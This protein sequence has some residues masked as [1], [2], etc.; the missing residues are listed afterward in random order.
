LAVYAFN[1][2]TSVPYNAAAYADRA[3]LINA[4]GMTALGAYAGPS[5]CALKVNLFSKNAAYSLPILSLVGRA[6]LSLSLSLS[7]NSKVWVKSGSTIYYDGDNGWPAPGWR[8][9]FGRIDGKYSGPDGYDHYYLV[10]GDGSITDLRYNSASGLY[11]SRNSTWMDFNDSTGVLRTKDGTQITYSS[12]GGFVQP[13]QI[14]D[15]NGNYITINYT[16]TGQQISSIVDTVGRTVSFSYNGDGTL[17]TITKSGFNNASRTWTFGY[18]STSLSC[19]FNSLTVNA[20]SSPK[21][22]TSLTYPNGTKVT[23][24]YNSCGQMYEAVS[25]SSSD[26]V[27]GKALITWAT[28][29][30]G[31]W[32]DSPVP[33]QVGNYDGSSTNY[34]GLT[35]NSYST[36]VSDPN[37]FNTITSFINSGSWDDGLP[38]QTQLGSTAMRVINNTWGHDGASANPRITQVKTTLSDTNQQSK[39]EYDYTSYGNVSE[40]REYDYGSG[41]P[42]SL[43]RK[44]TMTYE[45]G[46]NYTSRHIL[47]LPLT[48]IVYN[49]A[50]TAK[51]RTVYAYDQS[52]LTT[53]TGA[54]NHDDTNYGTG[55]VYRGLVT[56]VTRYTNAATPSGAVSNTMTYDMLGNLRTES[57]DCCVQKQYNFS[58]ATQYSQPDSVVRGSGTTL[59]TSAT[60]D[61]YT[62]L[63][64]SSTD[65]NNKT[66][67]YAYDVADRLTSTTR[68]DNTV[69]TTSYDDSSATPGTTSETPI[70][71]GKSIKR[72]TEFDGLGRTKRVI[73]KDYNNNIY[74]KGDTLYDSLGRT[75]KV[76]LPYTGASASYWTETVYD[77]LSRVTKVIPPDGTS[78]SNNIAYSYSGNTVTV[79]DQTGKQRKT[80]SDALGRMIEV[81]EPDPDNNNSL[82]LTTTYTYD[83]ND[84]LTQI[85]QGSQTRTYVYDDMGRKTSETTPEAGTVSYSYNNDSLLTSRT[86]ARGVVTTYTYDSSL[87]RLTQIS[88]NTN[89][90][91]TVASTSSVGYTYG[92]SAA[93]NN[94]GRVIKMTDGVGEEN[95]SYD[96][97]GRM[98]QVLKKIYN[99]NYTTSYTYNLAGQVA[100]MTYPSGRV[101]KQEYDAIGRVQNVKNNTTSANYATSATYN[102]ANQLTGFT[103]GNSVTASYGYSANRLQLASIAYAQGG[104]NLLSLSYSYSQS[105]AN[106]GQIA[107]ITDNNASGRTVNYTYDSLHRLKTAVTTGSAQ[108]PQWGLSWTYDRYGNRTAQTVTHGSGPSNSVSVSTSTNR[109]T[110]MGG[111]T[112]YYDANGN[113][114]QDDLYK[115]KYDAENRLVELRLLNDTLLATYAVDGNSLRVVK[116]W[117]GERTWYIYAGTQLISEYED[118][119]SATYSAGTNAGSGSDDAYSTILYQHADHL[120]TRLTTENSGQL[121]NAQ[122]H[123]PYGEALQ[124]TGTANPSVERKFTTYLKE[125]ETDATGGRLNYA[126]FRSHSA[127]TG[128]FLMADPVQGQGAPQRNNRYSYSG[129]DPVNRA[130]ANGL[131]YYPEFACS[132]L[133]MMFCGLAGEQRLFGKAIGDG[134]FGG[135]GGSSV[136]TTCSSGT[137]TGLAFLPGGSRLN[138]TGPPP[139]C[140]TPQSS[141]PRCF[142]QLKYRPVQIPQAEG[143]EHS[144]W[145]VQDRTGS[146]Y[147]VSGG[148]QLR[149]PPWGD[150]KVWVDPGDR[151]KR[152]PAD[153]S[154]QKLHWETGLSFDHCYGVDKLLDA[155]R[156]FPIKVS[157]VPKEGPNSN[158]AARY[159]GEKGNFWVPTAPPDAC[160]WEA[161]IKSRL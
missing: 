153:N 125:W 106:N 99:V 45:T 92:T 29:P 55:M 62:G 54:S 95:Y 15:R 90:C 133:E 123:Y 49:G 40:I 42:G 158:S 52:A 134:G 11:E 105:G 87:N 48:T 25:K 20:P 22:L 127:R 97:L 35:F 135:G 93:S 19:S 77:N 51:S 27:R 67:T 82:T 38:S 141:T 14:K 122:R 68:S 140:A 157:Y 71:S 94:N 156:H 26:A 57:A 6:G 104:S 46:S 21:L 91:S 10:S 28:A 113:L 159:L 112:F 146:R 154:R 41:A 69:F 37:S 108:D 117:S 79:T 147:I 73:T 33:S 34:W 89:C 24:A 47:G 66:M 70:E 96:S 116:V 43:T 88:Y 150:L 13:T 81:T 16:G 132:Y 63:L 110:A 136:S 75:W 1:P 64:A 3:K 114:T 126:V 121:G 148:P 111:Y 4:T 12:T 9:G 119:A 131:D 17:N 124:E 31:G 155:A 100:T 53:A 44:T 7:Y 151:G 39:V 2:P 80:K 98:T 120:T 36:T 72:T 83:P 86:D 76:S 30:G 107:G 101:L 144:F 115:Y 130:D 85:S 128:R 78:S 129:S 143:C 84:N 50:G 32:T 161:P 56:T 102:T 109:I 145:W 160:G 139:G 142:A 59:T 118:T 23:F 60:Y 65:E 149:V 5:T 74:S 61:S 137:P 138:P 152:F 18:T 103:Y 58:S 8:L